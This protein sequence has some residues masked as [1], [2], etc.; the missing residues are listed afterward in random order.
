MGDSNVKNIVSFRGLRPL[1]PDQGLCPWTPLGAQGLQL[2]LQYVFSNLQVFM[3]QLIAR[4][5]SKLVKNS[6]NLGDSNVKIS[7][8]SGG[9]ASWPLTPLGAQGLQ[10]S[11]QYVFSNL[12]V[13]MSQLIA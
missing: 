3:S 13:F 12:Q 5:G 4:N 9:F 2:S 1:T 10:L 7:S 8:A 6:V 11:F